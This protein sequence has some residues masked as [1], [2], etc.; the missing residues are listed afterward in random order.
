LEDTHLDVLRR[1]LPYHHSVSLTDDHD[2]LD[3]SGLVFGLFHQLG[4]RLLGP[5]A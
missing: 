5:S 3:Q 1:F 2:E 4:T